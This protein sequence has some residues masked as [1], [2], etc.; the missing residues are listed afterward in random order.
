MPLGLGHSEG[1]FFVV[2]AGTAVAV[3]N[4]G[5]VTTD[6]QGTSALPAPACQC[7]SEENEAPYSNAVE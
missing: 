1:Q 5:A 2:I 6:A 7:S 3:S 4:A